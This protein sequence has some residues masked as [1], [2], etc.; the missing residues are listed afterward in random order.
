MVPISM[1]LGQE[2]KDIRPT[3]IHLPTQVVAIKQGNCQ[4]S[5]RLFMPVFRS[6][7]ELCYY[8]GTL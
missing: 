6:I 5:Q 7:Q 1:Y 8:T 4:I 2:S 3:D